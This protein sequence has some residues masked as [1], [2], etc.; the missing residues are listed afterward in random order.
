MRRRV[1]QPER[2]LHNGAGLGL[3]EVAAQAAHDVLVVVLPGGAPDFDTL[4][5]AQLSAIP[6]GAPKTKGIQIG[7]AEAAALLAVWIGAEPPNE[8][9]K[10]GLLGGKCE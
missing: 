9:L 4:L 7:A 8:D 6:A 10:A 2:G 1:E 5:V 3:L